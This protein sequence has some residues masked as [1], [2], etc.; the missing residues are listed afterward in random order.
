MYLLLLLY[1]FLS[2]NHILSFHM[3]LMND[4]ERV[5]WCCSIKFHINFFDDCFQ[6]LYICIQ[7]LWIG[8]F[9]S[10]SWYFSSD[11]NWIHTFYSY[12]KEIKVIFW[13]FLLAFVGSDRE[14]TKVFC[15]L[16][17]RSVYF[18]ICWSIISSTL[19]I[20]YCWRL[21]SKLFWLASNC[22]W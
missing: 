17:Q 22:I 9:M 3:I 16:S 1:C 21:M 8:L 5:T 6:V 12:I 4:D 13:D 11:A 14:R 20:V 18:Q 7:L 19:I 10:F 2:L 15:S